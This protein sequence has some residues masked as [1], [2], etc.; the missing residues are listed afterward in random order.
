MEGILGRKI[1]YTGRRANPPKHP[2]KTPVKN[3]P[4]WQFFDYLLNRS[5]NRLYLRIVMF[6]INTKNGEL[7]MTED[8][9]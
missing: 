7:L 3:Q 4:Q 8:C 1:S 6:Y 9:N 5:F 2:N